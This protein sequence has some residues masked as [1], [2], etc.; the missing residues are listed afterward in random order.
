MG[1]SEGRQ[2]QA[3]PE[4]R[5]ND[6]WGTDVYIVGELFNK[7][8]ITV[9]GKVEMPG[10]VMGATEYLGTVTT[11]NY[12]NMSTSLKTPIES[13]STIKFLGG[14]SDKHSVSES[15][16]IPEDSFTGIMKGALAY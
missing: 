10:S 7:H 3:K 13:M 1:Y 16:D 11:S 6:T 4:G 14:K 9:T 5:I 2:W 15:S 8:F 12:G